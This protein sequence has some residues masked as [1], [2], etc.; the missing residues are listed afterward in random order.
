MFA[1]GLAPLPHVTHVTRAVDHGARSE[2]AQRLRND[3]VLLTRQAREIASLHATVTGLRSA[4]AASR[5]D[6]ASGLSDAT[7]VRPVAHDP[8]TPEITRIM[9]SERMPTSERPEIRQYVLPTVFTNN[10]SLIDVFA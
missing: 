5:A 4:L 6:A 7:V 3:E 2:C 10:G 1:S 8:T 9:P